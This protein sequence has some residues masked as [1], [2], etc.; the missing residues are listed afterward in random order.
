MHVAADVRDGAL[1]AQRYSI[2]G[3]GAAADDLGNSGRYQNLIDI[4]L[5]WHRICF[6]IQGSAIAGDIRYSPDMYLEVAS[7]LDE[8][9]IAP[10]PMNSN[11]ASS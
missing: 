4:V 3:A 11:S 8:P 7:Q 5:N 2:R 1:G 9:E 10:W 6:V